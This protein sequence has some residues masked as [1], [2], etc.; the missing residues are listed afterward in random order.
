MH[1]GW[2]AG[3]AVAGPTPHILWRRR[4]E[5]SKPDHDSRFVFHRAAE[6]PAAAERIL[7]TAAATARAR[8]A[9]EL[10]QLLRELRDNPV[11][12]A[13]SPCRRTLPELATILASHPLIHSAEGEL[14]RR[15]LLE[16]A[17]ELGLEV[18]LISRG[19]APPIGRIDPPWGKD[20]K[21][22]AGLAWAALA[23]N[24]DALVRER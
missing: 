17:Q 2:A 12:V 18:A 20:Q 24:P 19:V 5:L 13:L 3:V 1:T 8:A 16:G 22:A 23:S 21:D 15:A 6:Q 4:V 9:A 14:Y 11:L 7:A 10:R